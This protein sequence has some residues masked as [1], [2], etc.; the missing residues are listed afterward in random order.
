MK[1]AWFARSNTLRARRCRVRLSIIL[2]PRATGTDQSFLAT[3]GFQISY[4]YAARRV[5]ENDAQPNEY[6]ERHPFS[7]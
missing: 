2:M 6:G 4:L 3:A 7:L 5:K 1:Y